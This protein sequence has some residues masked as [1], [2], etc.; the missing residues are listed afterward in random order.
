MKKKKANLK[1]VLFKVS[2]WD[3]EQAQIKA[4]RYAEGNLSAWLRY[5]SRMHTPKR[6]ER[7][8]LKAR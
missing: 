4:D 7:I 1:M 3:Y 6:G 5:S 2:D 8:T